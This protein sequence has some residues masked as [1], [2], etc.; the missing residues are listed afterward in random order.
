MIVKIISLF[1]SDKYYTTAIYRLATVLRRVIDTIIG[2]Q[3]R[4]SEG[5]GLGT[6]A[7]VTGDDVGFAK[8]IMADMVT[9][10]RCEIF[11]PY[12]I[13]LNYVKTNTFNEEYK[14]YLK[15]LVDSVDEVGSGS[16]A[17]AEVEHQS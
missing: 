5:I 3:S 7:T 14:K 15:F 16:D 12:D 4:S 11:C 17:Q 9:P 6:I 8:Q 10:P 1:M 2:E 13:N